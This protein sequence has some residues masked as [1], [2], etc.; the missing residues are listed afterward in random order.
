MEPVGGLSRRERQIMDAVYSRGE[1]S[2]SEVVEAMADPPSRTAVRTML[3]ILEDKGHLTHRKQGRAFIYKP[4]RPR[5]QV[6][7]RAL[8]QVVK[9]FFDNSLER[10]LAAHLSDPSA[11]VSDEELKQLA[12]VIEQARKNKR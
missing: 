6:G 9:T 4:T 11:R 3:R 7:R 1:A 5:R 12:D 8:R 2:A 10:A